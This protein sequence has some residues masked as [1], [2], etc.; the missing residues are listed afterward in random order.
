[1]GF[2]A[3]IRS[4]ILK[5]LRGAQGFHHAL[6]DTLARLESQTRM[7]SQRLQNTGKPGRKA[8]QRRSR[9]T[10]IDARPA[11]YQQTSGGWVVRALGAARRFSSRKRAEKELHKH[12]FGSAAKVCVIEG[13]GGSVESRYNST[14]KCTMHQPSYKTFKQT[15]SGHRHHKHARKHHR[16][17][18]ASSRAKTQGQHHGSQGW[19]APGHVTKHAGSSRKQHKE[20]RASRR[21]K[22]Q[23]HHQRTQG[24][25]A[26]GPS[27]R[28]GGRKHGHKARRT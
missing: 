6:D 2:Q 14:H 12:T 26:Q 9:G 19:Q 8:K 13:L 22:A 15:H 25:H 23:H 27:H 1:M 4:D 21:T 16:E 28:H 18:R 3:V 24:K 7:S 5:Y 20:A 17:A 10:R 11:I